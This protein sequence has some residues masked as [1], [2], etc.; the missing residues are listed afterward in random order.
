MTPNACRPRGSS[1]S[2]VSGSI[3]ASAFS[4]D[5]RTVAGDADHTPHHA[6][7]ATILTTASP[8][9]WWADWGGTA[10]CT[11][12]RRCV[13]GRLTLNMSYPACHQS[14]VEAVTRAVRQAAD[15]ESRRAAALAAAD[16]AAAA[17]SQDASTDAQA[18]RLLKDQDAVVKAAGQKVDDAAARAARSLQGP[19]PFT[20]SVDGT[21][22]SG[23][24]WDA[25]GG[26][27]DPGW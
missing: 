21:T 12:G 10:T 26:N 22:D 5:L 19:A 1:R 25:W 27:P 9:T 3:P 20:A 8:A 6:P 24:A 15:A 7:R 14:A 16:T 17:R 4:E 2:V 23:W 11:V 18:A 13:I